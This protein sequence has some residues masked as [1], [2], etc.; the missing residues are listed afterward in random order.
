VPGLKPPLG[1]A[2]PSAV[3][4]PDAVEVHSRQAGEFAASYQA[5]ERDPYSNCFT[6]SR[7]RLQ[8]ALEESVPSAGAGQRAIDVGCGTGHHL[9]DLSARGF[10]VAGVDGSG[11][12]L[13]QAREAIPGA[14]LH[15]AGVE[16]LPFAAGS[17][18]L[19]VCIEVLRYLPDPEPCIAEMARVLRPGGIC[20]AT[21]AP[22]FSAN[23]YA[24][25][26]RLALIAPVGGLVRLKQFFTTP[27]QLRRQFERAGFSSVEVRGVYTGPINWIERLTPGRLPALLRRWERV[28]TRLADQPML[29]GVSN[30]LL[31]RAVKAP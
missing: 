20:V 4:G 19:A 8:A 1:D 31:V 26:N 30:M 15:Q 12:M 14:E 3:A 18:D 16:E 11:A 29:R 6:Y 10:E 24:L 21:A 9:R 27:S 7:M 5:L 13:E 2:R 28:A 25:V 22:R 23:G 17:F